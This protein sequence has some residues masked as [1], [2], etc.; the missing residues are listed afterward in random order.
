MNYSPFIPWRKAFYGVWGSAV[1]A[2]GQTF[3]QNLDEW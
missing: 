1:P 2:V 3:S